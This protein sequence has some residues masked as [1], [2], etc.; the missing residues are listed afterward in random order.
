M[1]LVSQGLVSTCLFYNEQQTFDRELTIKARAW[2]IRSEYTSFMT[3]SAPTR[4]LLS[5]V[6]L[7]ILKTLQIDDV[8]I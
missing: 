7:S 8:G 4:A 5:S 3:A 6:F 1:I 2:L